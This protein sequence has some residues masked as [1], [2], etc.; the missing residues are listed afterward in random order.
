[1]LDARAVI[2]QLGAVIYN[3]YLSYLSKLRSSTVC[4][5]LSFSFSCLLNINITMEQVNFSYSLKIIPLPAKD[6]YRKNLI[7][8]LESFTKVNESR[9]I[10]LFVIIGSMEKLFSIDYVNIYIFQSIVNYFFSIFF[11]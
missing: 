11:P 10:D 8:K 9:S 6:I 3:S 5:V 2:Y 1:M 7:H 4:R